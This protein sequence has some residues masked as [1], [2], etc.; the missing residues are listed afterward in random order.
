[1]ETP[2]RLGNFNWR[3]AVR[4]ADRE[5]D[6]PFTEITRVPDPA[7]PGDSL[8]VTTTYS[9]RYSTGIDWDTGINLPL[10]LRGSWKLQPSVGV[11]NVSPGQPY[12]IRNQRTDGAY[13]S[14]TKRFTINLGASPT[15]FGFYPGFA[16]FQ[17]I[18]HSFSPVISYAVAPEA[19]IPED[20]AA[21]TA[22]IG[23]AGSLISPKIQRLTVGLNQN[24]EGK[25]MKPGADTAA[26]DAST[27]LRLLS[28]VTSPVGYDFEQAKQPGRTGWTTPTLTNSFQSDM[29]PGFNL[30]IT[31][32]LWNGPVGYDSTSF[33]LALRQVNLS[34]AVSAATFSPLM[35]LFG[36]STATGSGPNPEELRGYV[37][38]TYRP[39]RPG[40]EAVYGYNPGNTP[41]GRAF[42]ANVS[43]T[44]SKDRLSDMSQSNIGFNTT[45]SP[46]PLWGVSWSTQYNVTAGSFES[47]IIR[48]E[49]ELHEWRAGFNFVRNPNG[50]VS[51]FFSISLTDLPAM[52]LDYNQ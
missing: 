48:L 44:Y 8:T 42:R 22:T 35:R 19:S 16:G 24:I 34:F 49:R 26:A 28:I 14:Q 51:L 40:P 32:D 11:T 21:A 15:F 46:T 1:M 41:L 5:D 12:L 17:R 43:Y 4:I 30:A 36:V 31:H 7:N 9:G 33:D 23:T 20:F 47:Q 2:L 37:A 50:N 6:I 39:V 45:F 29:L 25:R 3:N 52:K 13:V 18:R 27:K 38:D 10:L